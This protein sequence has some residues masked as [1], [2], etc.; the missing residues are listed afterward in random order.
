MLQRPEAAGRAD[1]VNELCQA[2][3]DLPEDG[4]AEDLRREELASWLFQLN[5]GMTLALFKCVECSRPYEQSGSHQCF[6][7]TDCKDRAKAR[8]LKARAM[9]RRVA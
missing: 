7:S 2:E 8:R 4:S 6:C 3:F 5:R 1:V 9:Y